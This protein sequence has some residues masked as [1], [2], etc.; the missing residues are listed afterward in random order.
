LKGSWPVMF[1]LLLD[2]T[3]RFLN[4][5]DARL[6]SKELYR[7]REIAQHQLEAFYHCAITSNRIDA[8]TDTDHTVPYGTALWGGAVPGTSC[9]ATIVLSL[10]DISQQALASSSGKEA[11]FIPSM[12]HRRSSR[13]QLV[14]PTRG[15]RMLYAETLMPR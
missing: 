14:E 6:P 3:E 5:R 13:A 10:R 8:H 2:V 11:N 9:Q 12:C 4:L 15:T 1:E 7:R